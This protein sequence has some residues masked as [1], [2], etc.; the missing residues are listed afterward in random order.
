[1]K[2]EEAER[3]IMDTTMKIIAKNGLASFS[4]RQ[5][6]DECG[7]NESLMY[8]YF[9]TKENLLKQCYEVLYQKIIAVHK[10]VDVDKLRRGEVIE[11]FHKM[12]I[13]MINLLI[14][15]DY[16]TLFYYEYC[17]YLNIKTEHDVFEK[18]TVLK[19]I[20]NELKVVVPSTITDE[21]GRILIYFLIDMTSCFAKRII[22]KNLPNNNQMKDYLWRVLKA[23]MINLLGLTEERYGI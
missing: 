16:R 8:R 15:E 7:I 5:I 1:M 19:D 20:M 17:E 18:N 21:E 13:E 14:S 6:T 3:I 23:G 12:Y 2:R 4:M 10:D 11:A 22:R 9:E